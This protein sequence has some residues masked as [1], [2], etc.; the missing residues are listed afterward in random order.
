VTSR[1]GRVAK[2]APAVIVFASLMLLP[3]LGLASVRANAG[4]TFL[5]YSSAAPYSAFSSIEIVGDLEKQALS[6]VPSSPESAD[7]YE[8]PIDGTSTSTFGGAYFGTLNMLPAP[9]AATSRDPQP[10][11]MLLAGLGLMALLVGR[12]KKALSSTG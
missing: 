7:A 4:A 9:A 10:Y 8:L 1:F 6:F 11:S 5:D 3:D 12:R 2:A